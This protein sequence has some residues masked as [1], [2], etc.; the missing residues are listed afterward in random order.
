M[1]LEC[2]TTIR[3]GPECL[4]PVVTWKEQGVG[5]VTRLTM[6][7]GVPVLERG[8]HR[9]P[10]R[11]GCF[12]EIASLLAGLPWSDH[13]SCTHPLV[14][15]I[16]RAV[17]DQVSDAARQRL[18]SWIPR[19]IGARRRH[20]LITASVIED[21]VRH[22]L[23][24]LPNDARLCSLLVHAQRRA[25]AYRCGGSLRRMWLWISEPVITEDAATAR[26]AHLVQNIGTAGGDE[27]LLALLDGALTT[28][29]EISGGLCPREPMIVVP[30]GRHE[31]PGG[32]CR[33]RVD[34]DPLGRSW[35]S[36][37]GDACCEAP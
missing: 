26:I 5:E 17:N 16:A 2:P 1:G 12:M 21:L 9:D 11:G 30:K 27:T 25:V 24:V 36:A 3:P 20:P 14:G 18:V 22:G 7:A 4:S 8:R 19:A 13:P 31:P 33:E 28:Y 34:E 15:A 6:S 10:Q 32:I 29:H 23:R 37:K 35:H